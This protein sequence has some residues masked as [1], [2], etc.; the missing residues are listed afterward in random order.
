MKTIKKRKRMLIFTGFFA[1]ATLLAL[2]YII[3]SQSMQ[4]HALSLDN[5]YYL[6]DFFEE[7]EYYFEMTSSSSTEFVFGNRLAHAGDLIS[8]SFN[9]G[10]MT[11]NAVCNATGDFGIITNQ[12]VALGHLV[13]HT[14]APRLSIGRHSIDQLGPYVDASFVPFSRRN[15]TWGLTPYARHGN[16]T[17]P[18]RLGREEQIRQPEWDSIP[19]QT[20]MIGRTSGVVRNGRIINYRTPWS[21]EGTRLYHQ[22]RLNH[23]SQGGDSGGPVFVVGDGFHGEQGYY[24]L[25]GINW[26]GGNNATASRI[27]LV[28]S[29]LNITPITLDNYHIFRYGQFDNIG[30]D[31]IELTGFSSGTQL[32][33]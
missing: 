17:F 24:Y 4:A 26:G 29:E 23:A 33:G 25:I 15:G 8:T 12:H 32:S 10:T 3:V 18:V 14:P 31:Y 13:Y 27:S 7:E 5:E 28:M 30:N 22:F 21:Q 6:V 11:I 9:L 19:T 2:S 1:I 16:Q 20:M